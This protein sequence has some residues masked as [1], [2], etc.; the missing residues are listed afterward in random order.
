MSLLKERERPSVFTIAYAALHHPAA[1]KNLG[2]LD[3]LGYDVRRIQPDGQAALRVAAL[4]ADLVAVDLAGPPPLAPT[5]V[6]SIR[7]QISLPIL[8]LRQA[9]TPMGLV[10]ACFAGGADDVLSA[11]ADSLE[12]TSRLATIGQIARDRQRST[13]RF[14][15][16][17]R[18]LA[19]LKELSNVDALTGL[20][21]R[22]HLFSL[23]RGELKRAR[24]YAFD[25]SVV[26]ADVDH[27]K[28]VNDTHGHDVG[29]EALVHVASVLSSAIREEDFLGRY[30]G[31]EFCVVLPQTSLEDGARLAERAR[32]RMAAM[33]LLLPG[34]HISLTISLGVSS[35][36]AG[37]PFD[38]NDL[39]KRADAELYRAKDSG[40]NRVCYQGQEA[41]ERRRTLR[42][43][44]QNG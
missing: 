1:E 38:L 44:T 35:F 13:K 27:F 42:V 29:D 4:H 8:L 19:K 33:P 11:S 41:A 6:A 20:Y 18:E 26:M 22:R 24:R 43:I 39:V 37:D 36:L 23:L 14:L 32:K 2:R 5:V 7:E 31:E 40:R 17:E 12:V 15:E 10:A 9:D 30:G 21:N 16:L 34:V 28:R 25:L 3:A